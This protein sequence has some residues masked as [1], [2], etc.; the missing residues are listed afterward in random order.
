MSSI[1]ISLDH[2]TDS[3]KKANVW[4]GIY[5][6]RNG[7]P[8]IYSE[9]FSDFCSELPNYNNI[10]DLMDQ[11]PYVSI[12]SYYQT[13]LIQ[14]LLNLLTSFSDG[15]KEGMEKPQ[16]LEKGKLK[17]LGDKIKGTITAMSQTDW[18]GVF[19]EL[20]VGG[21]GEDVAV[22]K[23]PSMLMLQ[24]ASTTGSSEFTLPFFAQEIMNSDGNY[25]WSAAKVDGLISGGTTQG[26]MGLLKTIGAFVTPI[27]NP[28]AGTGEKQSITL[29][30]DLFNDTMDKAIANIDFVKTII[31]HNMWLQYGIFQTPGALYDIKIGVDD[32]YFNAMFMC[33][34]KF[35]V[36]KKGVMR[37]MG[38]FFVP[39]VFNV[40]LSFSS[41][42]PSNVNTYLFGR[43]YKDILSSRNSVLVDFLNKAEGVFDK[44]GAS[45]AINAGSAALGRRSN[46]SIAAI[47]AAQDNA[48]MPTSVND[49]QAA[50]DQQSTVVD[51]AKQSI[52]N[53]NDG[54]EALGE[55]VSGNPQAFPG[56]VE[57]A[58]N[59]LNKADSTLVAA[60]EAATEA[61]VNITGLNRLGEGQAGVVDGQTY[62]V[63]ENGDIVQGTGAYTALGYRNAKAA[64]DATRYGTDGG[65]SY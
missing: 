54:K 44:I 63:D 26:P 9:P 41:L 13:T 58:E 40:S 42:L 14:G 61:N 53:I 29:E 39:D 65:S 62:G 11:I 2:R 22:E 50:I 15:V 25:G 51:V 27:F 52:Q 64:A 43:L 16:P 60:S 17:Q 34:G 46:E 30:F 35:S 49:I 56:A 5:D 37:K 31:V 6:F 32:E 48:T 23:L 4:G 12:K 8:Y 20:A 33:T 19:R 18:T 38:K 55:I 47:K 59:A 1:S 24:L 28:N 57:N 21:W 7:G 10:N 36:K 45:A 3:E